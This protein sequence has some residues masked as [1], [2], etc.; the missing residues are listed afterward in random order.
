MISSQTSSIGSDQGFEIATQLNSVVL[1]KYGD[2]VHVEDT[3]DQVFKCLD[4]VLRCCFNIINN[5]FIP[6]D[7]IC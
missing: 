5:I 2:T 4:D 1:K 7:A 6:Y 3:H